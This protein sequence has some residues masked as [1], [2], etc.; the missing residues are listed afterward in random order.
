MG[1]LNVRESNT[2]ES[3]LRYNLLNH[4]HEGMYLC[5]RWSGWSPDG[6]CLLGAIALSMGFN[7]TVRCL[8]INKLDSLMI[9]SPRSFL[10]LA[11]ES[12]FQGPFSLTW[13]PLLLMR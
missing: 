13:N 8:A 6:Q 3:I 2:F 12:M 4:H 7:Q 1:A 5:S 10:K 9:A 11:V